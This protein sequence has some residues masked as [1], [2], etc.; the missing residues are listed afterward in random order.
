MIITKEILQA[1][2]ANLEQVLI[3]KIREESEIRG[4]INACQEIIAALDKPEP[5]TPVASDHQEA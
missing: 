3:Q 1:D 5:A 2:I 4:K